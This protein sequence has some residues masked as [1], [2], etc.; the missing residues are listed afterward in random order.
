VKDKIKKIS[1]RK[2]TFWYEKKK[3]IL[4][5]IS[6][7]YGENSGIL[8]ILGPNGAGKTTLLRIVSTV[9]KP[10]KGDIFI[11][12]T[13]IKGYGIQKYRRNIG[14]LP[15][16]FEVYPNITG[17][18]F[19]YQMSFL[20]GID[21][22]NA[23]KKIAEISEILNLSSF[24]D[25][26]VKTYSG[27]MMR[28]MGLAQALLGDPKLLI[29]DEPFV[30]LDPSERMKLMQYLMF[31]NKLVIFS[32]HV[33][34]EIEMLC[35]KVVILYNGEILFYGDLETLKN[36]VSDSVFEGYIDAKDLKNVKRKEVLYIRKEERGKFYIR[37]ISPNSGLRKRLRKT[38]P[39]IYDAYFKL[40]LKKEDEQNNFK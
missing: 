11:N 29:L 33:L 4:R 35:S 6:F 13:N 7:E 15:Q 17:R 27:G 12:D 5:D 32:T 37:A 9:L 24:L 26:N 39:S 31:C 28:R 20:K 2:V 21:K 8:G 14:Y 40:V 3:P 22:K 38:S 18:D 16:V 23:S 30:G 34:S 10:K 19:L 36:T 25:K 1:V